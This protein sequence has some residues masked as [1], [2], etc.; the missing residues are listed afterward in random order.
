MTYWAPRES[1][2]GQERGT[3]HKEGKKESLCN[4]CTKEAW[5]SR[6][7]NRSMRRRHLASFVRRER[8]LK[9]I[10]SFPHSLS[11]SSSPSSLL[12][13]HHF[14]LFSLVFACSFFVRLVGELLDHR[15][16]LYM[17]ISSFFLG[18]LFC[19]MIF[20]SHS[21][22]L[23][24]LHLPFSSEVSRATTVVP[25][26]ASR[27]SALQGWRPRIAPPFV[28]VSPLSRRL[29]VRTSKAFQSCCLIAGWAK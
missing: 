7:K 4:E 5:I 18:V 26:A 27:H 24:F 20:F 12:L 19:F 16:V 11:C 17:M 22:I 21:I 15:Q 29:E 9:V 6:T 1:P 10:P 23:F 13:L 28:V 8:G 14:L 2:L 25:V 3:T